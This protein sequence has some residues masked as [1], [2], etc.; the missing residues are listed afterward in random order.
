MRLISSYTV[1]LSVCVCVCCRRVLP[2]LKPV[3]SYLARCLARDNNQSRHFCQLHNQFGCIHTWFGASSEPC[4]VVLRIVNG[5]RHELDMDRA[6]AWLR[7]KHRGLAAN[8]RGKLHFCGSA[9]SDASAA[10]FTEKC[11]LSC[12]SVDRREFSW[13]SESFFF[14]FLPSG[15]SES[16][17][18]MTPFS[19]FMVCFT[20]GQGRLCLHA[21]DSIPRKDFHSQGTAAL[22]VSSLWNRSFPAP[23]RCVHSSGSDRPPRASVIFWW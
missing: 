12:N 4:G 2:F 22:W 21:G 3:T 13:V 18:I 20:P 15:W 16:E 8:E 1:F 10:L 5:G 6:N 23:Q 19:F 11:F 9:K 14:Q 17:T 7:Q